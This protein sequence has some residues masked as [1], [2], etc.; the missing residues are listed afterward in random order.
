MDYLKELPKRFLMDG[1][2]L[3]YYPS[4]LD[5]FAKGERINPITVDMGI[6]KNCQIRCVY[7]YAIRQKP[8][9]DFIPTLALLRFAKDAGKAG[10]KGVAI[11]G[12][13]E[14]TLNMGLYP[15]VKALTDNGVRSAVATNGLLLDSRKIDI[16]VKNCSWVRFNVSAIKEKYSDIHRGTTIE[17]FKRLE[18]LIRYAVGHKGKCTI[19]LQMVLIPE[20]FE[21]VVDYAKWAV[22][23]GVDYA[24]IKQFSDA[25]E[26]MPMHFDIGRYKEVREGL[27][28]AER[29]S[30]QTTQIIIKWKAMK[31]SERITMGKSWGFDKCL[32]LPFLFQISGNGECYPCGYLF[33]K[34]QYCYGDITKQSLTE[35]L[36]SQRYWGIIRDIANTELKEL[37]TGQCRHCSSLKFIDKFLKGYKGNTVDT[38]IKMCGSKKQ[39]ELLRDNKPEHVEFL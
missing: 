30:N 1:C 33:N 15:F 32:D 35:I 4:E 3:L 12:D 13:G 29:L 24:Q 23:L 39:Y 22:E 8:S 34:K 36:D 25:G 6:H 37:C 20:C 26:G 28:E 2:K 31:D 10:V 7:C 11:I 17:D 5:K 9:R 16:L 19:G 14:P 18:K 21:Q 38:L 27:K